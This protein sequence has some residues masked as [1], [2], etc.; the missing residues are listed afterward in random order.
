MPRTEHDL[1]LT[2][3]VLIGLFFVGQDVFG[4]V[5]ALLLALAFVGLLIALSLFTALCSCLAQTGW[6]MPH[7]HKWVGPHR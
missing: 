4:L 1:P 6:S 3:Y 2:A 7:P 5:P